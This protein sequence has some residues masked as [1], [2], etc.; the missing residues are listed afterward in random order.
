MR[1]DPRLAQPLACAERELGDRGR[2]HAEQRRHR[3]R[4]QLLDLGVPE[5][6]LPACGQAAIRLRGEAAIERLVGGVRLGIRVGDRLDLVDRHLAVAAPPAGRGVTDAREE[7]RA[8]RSGR[9]APALDRLEDAR[10]RLLHEVVGV[11][12]RR[13]RGCHGDA[14]PVV[15]T[16]ELAECA[17]IA[18][19]GAL[20]E[21]GVGEAVGVGVRLIGVVHAGPG[22]RAGIDHETPDGRDHDA[23]SSFSQVALRKRPGRAA[24][25]RRPKRN[26]ENRVMESALRHLMGR[27]FS[28][29]APGEGRARRAAPARQHGHGSRRGPPGGRER[30]ERW[31]PPPRSHPYR[32]VRAV[33]QARA[34]VLTSRRR[35]AHGP[36]LRP[37][38]RRP[39]PRPPAGR[40][41]AAPHLRRRRGGGSRS[42][43]PGRSPGRARS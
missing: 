21:L 11:E 16:P 39:R 42:A 3:G 22:S 17:P 5:H 14:R 8:E 27:R 7:V 31:G 40:R 9:P 20:H 32:S 28:V 23:L 13:D 41:R 35:S 18:R 4:L 29:R 1:L 34:A 12:P 6:L 43:R 36:R 30:G 33:D 15:P 38:R 19:A 25:R 26:P 2:V 37:A 24:P 10:V